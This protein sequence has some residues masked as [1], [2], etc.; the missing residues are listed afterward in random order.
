MSAPASALQLEANRANARLSTG[1][2]TAQGK[3][4]SSRNAQS[5]GLTSRHALLPGEDA[6]EY[7]QHHRDR[8]LHYHPANPVDHAAVAELADLQWRLLR[9]PAFEAHL[10]SIEFRKLT[11]D[12]ELKPLIEKLESDEEI[13]ALAFQRLVESRVLTNLYN[14]EARL[15]RRA[16]KL[17][18]ILATRATNRILGAY[19]TAMSKPNLLNTSPIEENEPNC[20]ESLEI[21]EPVRQVIGSEPGR[22]QPCPCNSGLKYKRCCW[23]KPKTGTHVA[24]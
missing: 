1:P 9:V 2:R 14:L 22:N 4:A 3:Q 18:K 24:A 7:E 16:E 12:A 8:A 15:S 20:G 23:N 10:L 21:D 5:H 11:T 13:T 19:H 17:E 6:A